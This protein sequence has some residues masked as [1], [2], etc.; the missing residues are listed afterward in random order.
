MEQ[1]NV[2]RSTNYLFVIG[3]DR[4]LTYNVQSSNVCD[5]LLGST[6]FATGAKDLFLPSNKLETETLTMQILVSEDH[7]EWIYLYKWMLKLKN[8]PSMEYSQPCE[9]IALDANNSPST[10]FVY[11]DCFPI[12]VD[13][14]Q[15]SV[16]QTADTALVFNTVFRFNKLVVISPDGESI[17]DSWD[18][19]L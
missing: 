11:H 14:Q 18:G 2:A 16:L 9:L 7:R 19:D 1:R 15:Y 13:A 10:K 17:D 4:D 3:E 8:N 6:S 5:L 12:T